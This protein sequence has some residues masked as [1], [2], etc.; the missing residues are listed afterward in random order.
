ML[1]REGNMRSTSIGYPSGPLPRIPPRNLLDLYLDF[2]SNSSDLERTLLGGMPKSN[3]PTKMGQRQEHGYVSNQN[4]KQ[5]AILF[6]S[7]ATARQIEPGG[8]ASM[9]QE[10]GILSFLSASHQSG[11]CLG[12]RNSQQNELSANEGFFIGNWQQQQQLFSPDH[13]G[14]PAATDASSRFHQEATSQSQPMIALQQQSQ[15][16]Q[17]NFQTGMQEGNNTPLHF[18]SLCND[19]ND[20]DENEQLDHSII[21]MLMNQPLISHAQQQQQQ[22]QQQQPDQTTDAS[23]TGNWL[24]LQQEHETSFASAGGTFAAT[25]TTFTNLHERILQLDQAMERSTMS[26]RLIQD[27]DA[28]M[29]LRRCHSKTMRQTTVSRSRV[30]EMMVGTIMRGRAAAALLFVPK[31]A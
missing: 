26:Q 5:H 9:G 28:K 22:Q 10:A 24:R 23:C 13:P 6:N 18:S 2:N 11:T 17:Q 14:K 4:Q 25:C 27:W 20:D 31:Q 3:P 19:D 21:L 8:A 15:H 7:N 12:P 30:Q 16:H 29:G 1:E